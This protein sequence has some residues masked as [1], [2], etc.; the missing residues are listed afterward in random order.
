MTRSAPPPAHHNTA[1]PPPPPKRGGRK[2]NLRPAGYHHDLVVCPALVHPDEEDLLPVRGKDRTHFVEGAV[3]QACR[4]AIGCV[5]TVDVECAVAIARKHQ[6]A[7]VRRPG[8]S[9]DGCAHVGQLA[10]GASVGRRQKYFRRGSG[11]CDIRELALVGREAHDT[12]AE[13]RHLSQSGRQPLRE[14]AVDGNA[15]DFRV[16]CQVRDEG[17]V[18][19]VKPL[20]SFGSY[21]RAVRDE[22]LNAES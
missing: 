8:Q 9:A 13:K 22:L 3:R 17:D 1:P 5:D 21:A 6:A 11:V 14:A 10:G 19:G 18:F 15:P 2:E 4:A 7:A 16:S 20:G 12:G